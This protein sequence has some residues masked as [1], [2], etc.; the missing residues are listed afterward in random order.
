MEVDDATK[1]SSLKPFAQNLMALSHL[2]HM[3]DEQKCSDEKRL[4]TNLAFLGADLWLPEGR[5]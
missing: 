4:S 3:F 1:L 5:V 2:F